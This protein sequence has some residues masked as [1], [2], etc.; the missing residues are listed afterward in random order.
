MCIYGLHQATFPALSGCYRTRRH[1]LSLQNNTWTTNTTRH[2]QPNLYSKQRSL[3]CGPVIPRFRF[4]GWHEGPLTRYTACC[5]TEDNG[6]LE[7]CRRPRQTS[8]RLEAPHAFFRQEKNE[9][10]CYKRQP[11]KKNKSRAQSPSCPWK[12]NVAG[13]AT[14]W[15][16]IRALS[17]HTQVCL[18]RKSRHRRNTPQRGR[19]V[20]SIYPHVPPDPR[21]TSSHHRYDA[22]P[23]SSTPKNAFAPPPRHI[24]A[25]VQL[26]STV[27]LRTAVPFHRPPPLSSHARGCLRLSSQVLHCRCVGGRFETQ[28]QQQ[29]DVQAITGPLRV[30]LRE[31]LGIHSVT[32]HTGAEDSHSLAVGDA[33][34]EANP[35]PRRAQAGAAKS[36]STRPP[37]SL[38]Q[39]RARDFEVPQPAAGKGTELSDARALGEKRT[40][41]ERRS[42]Y[43]TTWWRRRCRVH[44]ACLPTTSM[45]DR[46]VWTDNTRFVP[47][48]R[49]R[50]L[51]R[52]RW[53]RTGTPP[54]RSRH[55]T[56]WCLRPRSIANHIERERENK[57]KEKRGTAQQQQP[58]GTIT[59]TRGSKA[60]CTQNAK[61]GD[62]QTSPEARKIA[63]RFTNKG[64][65]TRRS[66]DACE[67][68]TWFTRSVACER[69]FLPNMQD[70]DPS[71]QDKIPSISSALCHKGWTVHRD[72]KTKRKA[73]RGWQLTDEERGVI[74]RD[75]DRP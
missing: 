39:V 23:W 43:T 38:L 53:E 8:A 46:C 13:C 59:S 36:R 62:P 71:V 63:T 12:A 54:C 30:K 21:A 20:G 34:Q 47:E 68:Q 15:R 45:T 5:S 44:P 35:W 14:G 29:G 25:Q 26:L 11:R 22:A 51:P 57:M 9:H 4:R 32:E 74:E 67:R 17:V 75:D 19:I 16:K 41:E 7:G 28:A 3:V 2:T 55:R 66:P 1:A 58:A 52:R 56:A 6:G 61:S 33:H 40:E 37:S 49:W 10:N 72:W 42:A 70:L 27:L 50:P 65:S 24:S 18:L 69:R 60:S 31:R 64:R 73:W 48:G